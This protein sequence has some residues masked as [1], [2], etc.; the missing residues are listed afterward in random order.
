MLESPCLAIDIFSGDLNVT[1]ILFSSIAVVILLAI[2]I[3]WYC[4]QEIARRHHAE[5]L[6]RQQ[7]DRERL[8]DRI[9]LQIRQSLN[10]P[11][12]KVSPDRVF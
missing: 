2:A 7:T 6:L 10:R 3:F 1:N 8:V 12:A 11:P 4:Y 5:R 9:A